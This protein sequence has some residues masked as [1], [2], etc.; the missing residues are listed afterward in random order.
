MF[1]MP[2]VG[3]WVVILLIAILLFGGRRLPELGSS[4]GRGIRNFKDSLSPR[5]KDE[6]EKD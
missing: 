2:G 1:S 4:L 6:E 5:H 3:E